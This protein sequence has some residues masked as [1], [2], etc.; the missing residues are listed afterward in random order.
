MGPGDKEVEGLCNW[1]TQ[2]DGCVRPPECK[3]GSNG[4]GLREMAMC[5]CET[6]KFVASQKKFKKDLA[7]QAEKREAEIFCSSKK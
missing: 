6:D 5:T 1:M 3:C 7:R 2:R 4:P